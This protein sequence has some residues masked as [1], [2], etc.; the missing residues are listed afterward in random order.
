MVEQ[1]VMWHSYGQ[2]FDSKEDAEEYEKCKEF[3]KAV[4]DIVESFYWRDCE[5]EDVVQGIIQNKDRLVEVL[6]K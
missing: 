5:G 6:R 4:A 2:L 1:V 3:E